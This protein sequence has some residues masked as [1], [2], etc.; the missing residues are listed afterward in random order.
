MMSSASC[1]PRGREGRAPGVRRAVLLLRAP[2]LVR[3][4]HLE[5][6]GFEQWSHD[7]V[8]ELGPVGSARRSHQLCQRTRNVCKFEHLNLVRT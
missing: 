3:D 7:L 8:P 1:L 6:P 5:Q 2:R 4:G